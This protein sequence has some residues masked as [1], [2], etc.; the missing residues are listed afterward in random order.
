V[1]TLPA[2][3]SV[4]GCAART[5][6]PAV[7]EAETALDHASPATAAAR[8]GLM[9]EG[10]ELLA[11]AKEHAARGEDEKA[12]LVARQAIQ[13]FRTAHA[14][15][16]REQAET[17]LA[18]L[19]KAKREGKSP[20]KSD[21]ERP[22]STSERAP[23]RTPDRGPTVVVVPGRETREIRE[24]R[25]T[26][27]DPPVRAAEPV[28]SPE[29]SRDGSLRSLAE[30]KIVELSFKKSEALGQAKDQ[31]CGTVYREYES[32][33]ELAQK[34]FDAQDYERA[35]EFA[36][37]AEE[38]FRAC[39]AKSS[40]V[41]AQ[42]K[43][44]E[45]DAAQKKASAAVQKAQ[46]ELSRAEAVASDDPATLQGKALVSGALGWFEKKS[47]AEAED[48]A[49]RA[50]AVLV[51]VQP[52]PKK[53]EAPP[54]EPKRAEAPEPKSASCD[55]A[56]AQLDEAKVA[57][58]SLAN[59]KLSETDK[60]ARA[61][62]LSTLATAEKKLKERTCEPALASA[63]TAR[64]ELSRLVEANA[65]AKKPALA[66]ARPWEAAL[67]AIQEAEKSKG[68]AKTRA[69]TDADRTVLA[70]GEEAL[71]K[72]TSAYE[73]DDLTLAE[74]AA[75]DAR[76]FFDGIREKASD[77][78]DKKPEVAQEAKPEP[79]K[80]APAPVAK[81]DDADA[82]AEKRVAT[83]A[84]RAP[85][86]P[87]WKTA[88]ARVYRALALRDEAEKVSP[89]ERD[90]LA[91][92][93]ESLARARAD[94]QSK[95]YAEARAKADSVIALL[96]PLV[97][98][99]ADSGSSEELEASRV[100]GDAALREAGQLAT[101]CEK[102][103]CV[104]R[105]LKKL[106]QA[107]E[108]LESARRAYDAK[109]YR[110]T[111]ELAERAGKAFDEVL[112]VALP[113]T[114]PTDAEREKAMRGEAED[115]LR[116]A[117][118]AEKLCATKGCREREPE[119]TLRARETLVSAQVACNDKRYEPCRDRARAA[120]KAYRAT[121]ASAPTFEVPAGLRGIVRQGDVLLLDPPI[122]FTNGT[123]SLDPK[124]DAQV[125]ALAKTLVDNRKALKKVNLV[126]YTDNRGHAPA[127]K[128]LS[129][130]R[131]ARLRAALVSKGVPADLL[132]SEGRGSESPVDD[133]ATERGRERNR[134]VEVRL[135][136]EDGA[137]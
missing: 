63:T 53:P 38:R 108:L 28:R 64:A 11:K 44:A 118:V 128:K 137:K 99:G 123:S 84:G 92:V 72:A 116:D 52:K 29:P 33:L 19:E 110:A 23:E 83:Y 89:Q 113:P 80:D 12:T 91:Q 114:G 106:A 68:L 32:I 109:R 87:A 24:T 97:E 13:K 98:A 94:W 119:G 131:A 59:E 37:R 86:D 30:R 95:R 103:R 93:D 50:F 129:A 3:G 47:F 7:V 134:R 5:P 26:R 57:D 127:N 27:V 22:A 39:D 15:A 105:D 18:A 8:P 74:Q 4:T 58:K 115:A 48:L 54:L 69:S 45:T 62:A 88:Y 40:S 70:R 96:G 43:S 122:V 71:A 135:E 120:E 73:K 126:G 17:F 101:V 76:N 82:V 121:L 56:K 104:D 107:K 125:G 36:L 136:L 65:K 35:Y 9:A 81:T 100:R 124:S 66:S 67:S 117:V 90:K 85:T 41:L 6:P 25:E 77:K 111:V 2:L 75:K 51:R 78:A 133:N 130:D 10:K 1:V 42:A 49:G 20:T 21:P 14:L 46:I 112:H 132:V 34:R 16:E 55:D 31:T 61:E 102:E 60:K 79:R